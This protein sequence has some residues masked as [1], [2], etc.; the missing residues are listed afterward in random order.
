MEGSKGGDIV[1]KKNQAYQR[2]G[3]AC[4]SVAHEQVNAAAPFSKAPSFFFFFFFTVG[5][6][7]PSSSLVERDGKGGDSSSSPSFPS[8]PSSCSIPNSRMV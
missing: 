6:S 5:M 4:G 8:F 1:M 2:Q 7:S 3:L